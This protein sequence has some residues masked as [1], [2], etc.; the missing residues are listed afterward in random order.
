ML[1]PRPLLAAR[2]LPDRSPVMLS[3][4][5]LVLL[6]LRVRFCFCG[7]TCPPIPPMGPRPP[8]APSPVCNGAHVFPQ[9]CQHVSLAAPVVLCVPVTEYDHAGSPPAGGAAALGGCWRMAVNGKAEGA[10]WDTPASGDEK[11][12]GKG[13]QKEK[14]MPSCSKG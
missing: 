4:A 10:I 11:R 5:R 7:R 13:C 2:D 9:A 12:T 6:L 14:A 3:S 1:G 8:S